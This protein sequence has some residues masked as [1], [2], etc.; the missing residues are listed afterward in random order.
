MSL[1]FPTGKNLHHFKRKKGLAKVRDLLDFMTSLSKVLPFEIEGPEMGTQ[2]EV[3]PGTTYAP[4]IPQA[5]GDPG[6]DG[7]DGPPGPPGGPGYSPPGPLG[8]PGP[9]GFPGDPAPPGPGPP[10]P[11]GPVGPMGD[12]PQGDKGPKG[13]PGVSPPGPPGPP[14]PNS[15][16]MGPEGPPGTDAVGNIPGQPGANAPGP[17]GNPGTPGVPG[18]PGQPGPKGPKGDKG[19]PGPAGNK[20]AIVPVGHNVPASV[21]VGFS[22]IESPRCL[23]LDHLCVPVPRD[24]SHVR[25]EVDPR[26]LETLDQREAVE[27]LSVH[28]Q[29]RHQARLIEGQSERRTAVVE[30]TVVPSKS[31]RLAV[32]TVAGIARSHS[33]RRFPEFTPEQMQSNKAFWA[34]AAVGPARR[35]FDSANH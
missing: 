33:G 25:M 6:P 22:V 19:F 35:A 15:G 10:G 9:T 13:N 21:C 7:P 11:P 24:R 12:S 32:V 28:L 34:S 23:W 18:G 17:P 8:P 26:F 5:L 3:A 30:L 27:I 2:R 16:S 29:G 31:S 20:L 1:N 4:K 14:G